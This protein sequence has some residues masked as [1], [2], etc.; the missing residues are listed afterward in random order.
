MLHQKIYFSLG[1]VFSLFRVSCF[2]VTPNSNNIPS[3]NL[4]SC[5]IPLC[6]VHHSQ[7]LS[8]TKITKKLWIL[9]VSRS[10]PWK[11]LI[12]IQGTCMKWSLQ[13]SKF[14]EERGG[15]S[16]MTGQIHS[17]KSVESDFHFIPEKCS[18][19]KVM[20]NKWTRAMGVGVERFCEGKWERQLWWREAVA[21]M[22]C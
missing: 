11:H 14:P 16:K 12:Y 5:H 3:F 1:L 17:S 2:T 4:R 7:T 20:I 10:L 19:H 6:A 8:Q 13:S 21:G 15:F 22:K 18:L 9:Q